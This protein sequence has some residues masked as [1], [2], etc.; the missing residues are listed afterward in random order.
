MADFKEQ[1]SEGTTDLRTAIKLH[2]KPTEPVSTEV[3]L[4]YVLTFKLLVIFYSK[5]ISTN[6]HMLRCRA[7]DV[8]FFK[9]KSQ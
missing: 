7:N 2:E 9:D 6:N 5:I 1:G 8:F 4:L 3:H